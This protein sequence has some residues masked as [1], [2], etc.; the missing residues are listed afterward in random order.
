MSPGLAWDK[1]RVL[2]ERLPFLQGLEIAQS[3]GLHT[4][5]GSFLQILWVSVGSKEQAAP[6]ATSPA[7][8]PSPPPPTASSFMA[9]AAVGSGW[10]PQPPPHPPL[11]QVKINK[12]S[13]S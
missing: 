10:G 4:V 8:V 5:S 3:L 1:F 6:P 7:L 2:G 9:V 11:P 13:V 12:M